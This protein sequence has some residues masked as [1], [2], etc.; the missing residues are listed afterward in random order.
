M[1]KKRVGTDKLVSTS[2]HIPFAYL[3]R[4]KEIGTTSSKFIREAVGEK[5][6]REEGF[7]AA[8][9]RQKEI[10][11]ELESELK[12]VKNN[13]AFFQ[14]KNK[15]WEREKE[16]TRIRDIIMTEYLTRMLRTEQELYAI[17]ESQIDTAHDLK[18]IV[19]DIWIEI[20]GVKGEKEI[21]EN[22]GSTNTV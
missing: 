21:L 14:K 9:N 2:A 12:R 7:I 3:E 16:I 15:E 11:R 18:K 20:K 17:V 22:E 10:H 5:L 19:H 13:I 8:I 1:P 6:E 4:I